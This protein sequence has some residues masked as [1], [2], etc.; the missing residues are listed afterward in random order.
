MSFEQPNV[1]PEEEKMM[2]RREFLKKPLEVV[3]KFI[4]GDGEKASENSKTE[5]GG[6]NKEDDK[7]V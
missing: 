7:G 6:E 4:K 1:E 3:K 2:T 5:E